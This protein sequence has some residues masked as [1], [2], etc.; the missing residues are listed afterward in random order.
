MAVLAD[1]ERQI[2]KADG[3]SLCSECGTHDGTVVPCEA[4]LKFI[5]LEHDDVLQN[6]N[7]DSGLTLCQPCGDEYDKEHEIVYDDHG[8]RTGQAHCYDCGIV[9]VMEDPDG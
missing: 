8:R 5:C 6:R 1:V 4:C 7:I 9:E 3:H 2:W